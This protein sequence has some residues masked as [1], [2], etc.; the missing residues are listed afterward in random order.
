MA[1][2]GRPLIRG[3][4]NLSMWNAAIAGR[5]SL[6]FLLL[7]SLPSG[8]LAETSRPE[9]ALWKVYAG[10]IT[11]R[12]EVIAE[13]ARSTR[14]LDTSGERTTI[15]CGENTRFGALFHVVFLDTSSAYLEVTWKYPHL[16]QVM[17]EQERT[18]WAH[19]KKDRLRPSV[20]AMRIWYMRKAE[21]L[22]GDI[23]LEIH[24]RGEILLR[25]VFEV[26]GCAGTDAVVPQPTRR[27]RAE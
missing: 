1:S 20:P 13:A 22:D 14:Q 19:Y 9:V 12:N 17:G 16:A 2:A 11:S 6:A 27:P 5:P 15:Q 21:M 7:A 25:H 8:G 3:N 26:R 4:G 10:P 18:R 23:T 24:K